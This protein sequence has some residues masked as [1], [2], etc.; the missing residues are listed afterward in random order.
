MR[1][2]VARV[3]ALCLVLSL[4][5]SVDAHAEDGTTFRRT[6]P[7][8][9]IRVTVDEI[10]FGIPS[11][12]AWGLESRL[13]P[14]RGGASVALDLGVGDE[15][16][17]ESFVR[18]AWYGRDEGRPRQ[19]LVEDAP[20]VLPGVRRRVVMQLAPPDGAVAFRVRVL[21]RVVP[22]TP[23]SREAAIAVGRVRVDPEVRPRPALT[24]LWAEPP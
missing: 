5:G 19:M 1:R 7:R 3:L 8:A 17:R 18:I 10:A 24:R 9:P 16:V 15:L 20:D 12:R 13:I 22:G 11:G 14:I 23:S 21:A 4:T 6:T 2:H